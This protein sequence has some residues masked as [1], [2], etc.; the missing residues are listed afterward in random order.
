VW[1]DLVRFG[2]DVDGDSN[3]SRA[4]FEAAGLVGGVDAMIGDATRIGTSLGYSRGTNELGAFSD[5]SASTRSLM[6]AIYAAHTAGAWSLEGAFGYGSHTVRT[7]RDIRVGPASRQARAT[8]RADQYSGL[9]RIGIALPSP[10]ALSLR[11]F[12]ELR[13]STIARRAFDEEGAASASLV[14]VEDV[15]VESLRSLA[16]IRASWAPR[17]FGMRVEPELSLAWAHEALDTRGAMTGTLDGA[18]ALAG[19]RTFTVNGPLES[20]DGAVIALGV[21][22]T[23]VAHGRA[24]V[25]YE[26]AVTETG[27]EHGLTAGLRFVW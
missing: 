23:L 11:P 6:P 14:N 16:G 3:A 19:F 18:T 21:S 2:G 24:F 12:V 13:Y 20:R 26:G 22:T 25:A 8:Y 4:T 27:A 15:E 10:P 5:D 7:V 17:A 1:T 9:A